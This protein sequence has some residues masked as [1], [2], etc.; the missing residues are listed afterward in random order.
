MSDFLEKAAAELNEKLSGGGFD[1]LAKLQVTDLGAIV[2]DASGARVSDDE[3][4]VTLSADAET[5][6]GIVSGETNP[7]AAFMSGKLTIDGDMGL[8]MKLAAVLA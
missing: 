5:F 4:D 7:T 3:A 2:L 1:G 8:A 6:E